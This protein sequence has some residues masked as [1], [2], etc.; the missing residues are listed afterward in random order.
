MEAMKNICCVNSE[1]A[2]DQGTVTVVKE[3]L[4]GFQETSTIGW[5]LVSLKLWFLSLYFKAERQ[6]P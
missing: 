6:T 3:I 1:S 4:L 2:V 5:N